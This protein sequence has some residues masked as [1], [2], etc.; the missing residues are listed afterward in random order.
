MNT[1]VL[2]TR[3]EKKYSS[4]AFV[5]A[6]VAIAATIASQFFGGDLLVVYGPLWVAVA[7]L[8]LHGGGAKTIIGHSSLI[9]LLAYVT[10]GASC[11]LLFLL[12]GESG[13]VSSIFP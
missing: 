4:L 3:N 1:G 2:Y 6:I 12:P 13:Y 10:F 9:L 7:A 8:G 11:S 5:L